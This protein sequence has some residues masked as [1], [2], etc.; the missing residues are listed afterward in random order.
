MLHGTH[1]LKFH[2]G[3]PKLITYIVEDKYTGILIHIIIL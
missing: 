2:S 1:N 3:I